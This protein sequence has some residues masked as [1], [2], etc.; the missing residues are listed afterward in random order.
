MDDPYT[1][2]QITAA[3]ALSDLDAMCATSVSAL[4]VV[5]IPFGMDDT[6]SETLFQLLAGAC[7]VFKEYGVSLVGGH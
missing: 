6:V 3:H 4:A 7:Q 2:G 5:M 1:F